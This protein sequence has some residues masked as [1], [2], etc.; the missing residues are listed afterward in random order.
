MHVDDYIDRDEESGT[1]TLDLTQMSD[2][3][4]MPAQE[5]SEAVSKAVRHI[6]AN[7]SEIIKTVT[8]TISENIEMIID[9]AV[10]AVKNTANI[11]KI[12]AIV[13]KSFH[14]LMRAA[15]QF[16]E[17]LPQGFYKRL[18]KI[19]NVLIRKIW[20][21]GNQILS[22]IANSLVHRFR[23]LPKHSHSNLEILKTLINP[24]APNAEVEYL[25]ASV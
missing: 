5:I 9:C 1:L 4:E 7:M 19:K 17:H 16:S 21:R 22:M 13:H 23:L 2:A 8:E 18:R 10:E 11:A 12:I 24:N 14:P 15:H 3:P 20:K 6:A 25:K